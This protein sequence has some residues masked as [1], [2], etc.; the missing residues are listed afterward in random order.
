M[1]ACR[2]G[3]VC[4]LKNKAGC[5]RNDKQNWFMNNL[6]IINTANPGQP[7]KA[8]NNG[9]MFTPWNKIGNFDAQHHFT[10]CPMKYEVNFIWGKSRGINQR[11]NAKRYSTGINPVEEGIVFRAEDYLYSS[12]ADYTCSKLNTEPKQTGIMPIDWNEH[13]KIFSHMRMIITMRV[14]WVTIKNKQL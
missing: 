14:P 11:F 3:R 13:D 7:I 12:A 9:N 10:A 4:I 8:F 1:P 6:Q 2:S 5:E